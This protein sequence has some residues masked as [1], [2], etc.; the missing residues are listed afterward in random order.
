MLDASVSWMISFGVPVGISP[1]C[2]ST[3]TVS[4]PATE[5]VKRG[6]KLVCLQ[7]NQS[8]VDPSIAAF[9]FF[10]PNGVKSP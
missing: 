7:Q 2:S 8:S 5:R 9:T 6:G 3:V 4:Y 10:S 1:A